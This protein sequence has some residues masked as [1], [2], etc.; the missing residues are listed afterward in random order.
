MMVTILDNIT[1]NGLFE[2]KQ[3]KKKYVYC[4]CFNLFLK[5]RIFGCTVDFDIENKL[6]CR[7]D[8]TLELTSYVDYDLES[9]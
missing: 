9:L 3:S 4:I 2:Q 7:K 5:N 8:F 6:L 1:R